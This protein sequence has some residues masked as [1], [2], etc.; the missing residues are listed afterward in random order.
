MIK[1]LLCVLCVLLL[2]VTAVFADT[3]A[4]PVPELTVTV[5]PDNIDMLRFGNLA[6]DI[7]AD[8]FLQIFELGDIVTVT[9]EGFESLEAPVC[10]SYDDV[11]AG[12]LLIYAKAGKP[13]ILLAINYGQIGVMMDILEPS[14]D[15]ATAF[16]VKDPD[17]LPDTVTVALKEAGGYADRLKLSRLVRPDTPDGYRDTL[18]EAQFANFR[19]ITTTGM[20]RGV[21]Y[22]SS[23]P[24]SPEIGRNSAADALC[25]A[26]GIRTVLNLSDTAE[27]AAGYEGFDETYYR[28]QDVVYLA[29]PASFTTELFREKLAEGLRFMIAHEGPYLVHCLEGKDRAGFVSAMLALFMGASPDEVCEDYSVTY[30]NYFGPLA[31][32]EPQLDDSLRGMIR[33]IIIEN[34]KLAYG[35]EALTDE[36]AQ[37][38]T[39]QYIRSLGLSEEEI[40]LLRERLR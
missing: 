4:P 23:S 3:P 22:R 19:E 5:V 14:P 24:I 26:A 40:A 10:S 34:L 2:T 29:M 1:K 21:L 32:G 6:M 28:Q 16:R 20:G 33:T 12:E 39:V 11:S 31:G 8:D 13:Y 7:A 27:A 37:S 25:A 15:G 35:V 17:T 36:N 18:T 38:A 9:V 30:E